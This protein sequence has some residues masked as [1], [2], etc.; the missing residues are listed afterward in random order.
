MPT[1]ARMSI[2]LQNSPTSTTRGLQL[3]FKWALR[4]VLTATKPDEFKTATAVYDDV[5]CESETRSR[6]LTGIQRQQQH[7]E[8]TDMRINSCVL[9]VLCH[10]CLRR[11]ANN[12]STGE[13]MSTTTPTKWFLGRFTMELR[14]VCRITICGC[15]GRLLKTSAP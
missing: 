2:Q 15:A 4:W 6:S 14:V 13:H 5:T 3:C 12:T 11:L 10:S 8:W 1:H 7:H 9:V